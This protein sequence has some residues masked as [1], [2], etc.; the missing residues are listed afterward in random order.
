MVNIREWFLARGYP[1][2]MFKEQMKRVVFGKTDKTQE[3]STK[4][5]LFRISILNLS[6]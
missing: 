2:K 3:D 5:Y 1:E 6:F 4:K